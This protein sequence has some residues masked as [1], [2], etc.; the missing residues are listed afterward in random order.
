MERTFAIVSKI[1]PFRPKPSRP[2]RRAN[3][4]L[5]IASLLNRTPPRCPM[6]RL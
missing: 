5:R 4:I 1:R 2:R 3:R 6:S